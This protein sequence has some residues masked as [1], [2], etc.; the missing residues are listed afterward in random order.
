MVSCGTIKIMTAE[1]KIKATILKDYEGLSNEPLDKEI[2][3]D[4][5]DELFES[6]NKDWGLQDYIEEFRSC[7]NEETKIECDF[8][9]HYESKSVAQQVFDG[10]WV[11]YTYWYGGGKHGEP[12]A[13]P[14][15]EDA[16]NLNVEEKEVMIVQRTFS[17]V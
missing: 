17:K 13:M 7:Y 12:S 6:L 16:Y 1:Q 4:T 14:W 2:T 9:R 11:G 3:K 10:S 5:V 8:S 15:M